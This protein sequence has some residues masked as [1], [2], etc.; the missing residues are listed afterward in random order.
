MNQIHFIILW[1]YTE[2]LRTENQTLTDEKQYP[3]K[4]NFVKEIKFLIL[5]SGILFTYFPLFQ[6][7]LT[8]YNLRVKTDQCIWS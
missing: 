4:G 5:V 2:G 8:Y 1:A 3:K 6:L 7:F